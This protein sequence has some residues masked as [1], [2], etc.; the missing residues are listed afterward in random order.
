MWT[1]RFAGGLAISGLVGLVAPVRFD[2]GPILQ[3]AVG[4]AVVLMFENLQKTRARF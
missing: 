1:I 3:V 2:G 4:S